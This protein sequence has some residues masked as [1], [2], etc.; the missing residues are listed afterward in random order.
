MLRVSADRR[1]RSSAFE[2]RQLFA[3][4]REAVSRSAA[5]RPSPGAAAP[6]S[7]HFVGRGSLGSAPKRQPCVVCRGDAEE[8]LRASSERRRRSSA[9]EFSQLFAL[10][11][12]AR[13]GSGRGGP[14]SIASPHFAGRGSWGS[15]PLFW[16]AIVVPGH[17]SADT[18]VVR[19]RRGLC[20]AENHSD[21]ASRALARRLLGWL[22]VAQPSGRRG[23][24][25]NLAHARRT[26]WTFNRNSPASR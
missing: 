7:P 13:R 5:R 1:R 20:P 14:R 22:V 18:C 15:A 11:R 12:A 16:D 8:M 10:G 24:D 2:F 19:T 23:T 26:S 9:F 25:S 17:L 6:T 4:G 3:L 21:L